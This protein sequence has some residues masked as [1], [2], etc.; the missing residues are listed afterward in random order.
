MGRT[1]KRSNP[2]YSDRLADVRGIIGGFRDVERDAGVA[3]LLDRA[4]RDISAAIAAMDERERAEMA[5][6]FGPR[7]D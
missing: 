4:D 7:S 1:V 5:R 3:E 6:L 2:R